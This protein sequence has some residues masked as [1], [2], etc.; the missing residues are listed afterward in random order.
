[1]TEYPK[2]KTTPI[3]EIIFNISYSENVENDVIKGF[4]LIPEIS[5]KYGDIKQGFAANIQAGGGRD[6]TTHVRNDG[7][8]LQSKTHVIQAKVGSFAYHKIKDYEPFENLY[9][10]ITFLWDKFTSIAG[11]LSINNISLRYLNF[12]E[13][14]EGENV[15]EIIN[16]KVEHPYDFDLQNKLLQL[17][18]TDKE[19]PGLG[20]NVV[21]ARGRDEQQNGIILDIILNLRINEQQQDYVKVFGFF[22]RMRDVKNK[23]FFKTLSDYTLSKYYGN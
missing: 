8:M 4:C 23:I 19:T 9:E 21:A 22:N 13:I 7:Y 11:K 16:V 18:F 10:Q 14:N 3:K 15:D 6:I 12:I 5:S 1:M 17:H 20:I 2:L